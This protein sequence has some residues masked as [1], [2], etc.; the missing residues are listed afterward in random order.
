VKLSPSLGAVIVTTGGVFDTGSIV[1]VIESEPVAPP[2][3]P[4]SA[5]ITC[6]PTLKPVV[7][8][9]SIPG[10]KPPS[11]SEAQSI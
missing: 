3:S 1:I 7:L 5:V 2:L 6:V 9:E 11:K 4:T 8:N 10:A